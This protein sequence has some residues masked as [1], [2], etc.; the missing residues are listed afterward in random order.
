MMRVGFIGRTKFLYDTIKIFRAKADVEITFIWTSKE[1][2][3]Y[4][5]SHRKFEAIANELDV[6]FVYSSTFADHAE[7][8]EAD[9]VI[10]INFTNIIPTS[11][12]DRFTYGVV[13]AHLGDL[14][15]YRGNACPNWAILNGEKSVVLSFHLMDAG[16][17]TGPIIL[18]E[19]FKLKS[20]TFIGEIYEW[21]N[22]VVPSGFA[23]S[24]EK[25]TSGAPLTEQ[26]G[27]ALRAFPRKP[28]DSRLDFNKN[29]DW[30]YR[31]IRASSYPFGGAFAYLNNTKT[32]VT[33]F[34]AEPFSVDYDFLAI[35]G[36]IMDKSKH[37]YSFL[38]AIGD[39]VLRIIAYEVEGQSFEASFNILCGSMRNRLT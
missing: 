30:N 11:F 20:D 18:Q 32:K 26:N 19:T 33:I 2:E 34:N 29:L 27:K 28:E 3:Y 24:F 21:L 23:R 25:L 39:E 16:L 6:K 5:F 38:L 13:N 7:H 9:V 35:S 36:Q 8:V 1:E 12:I 14:P 10:S 37:D 4:D 22:G 17:D 31:M 15:R